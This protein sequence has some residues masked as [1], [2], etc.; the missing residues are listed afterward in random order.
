[1]RS[2]PAASP[3]GTA[4]A[5]PVRRAAGNAP[6]QAASGHPPSATPYSW[7]PA[8][9]RRTRFACVCR[10]IAGSAA[11][12]NLSVFLEPHYRQ[13][14]L[15]LSLH[16]MILHAYSTCQESGAQCQVPIQDI[17]EEGG[18]FLSSTLS[19]TR[20]S[21]PRLL[22]APTMRAGFLSSRLLNPT[23]KNN[24]NS[25]KAFATRL[26]HQKTSAAF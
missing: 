25:T 10:A 20:H 13:G 1:C 9:A 14:S 7:L 16:L 15:C 12:S 8:P 22:S 17:D 19:I 26:L 3:S 18:I 24:Q 6:H 4:R 2:Q 11:V 5:L 23:L 21:K